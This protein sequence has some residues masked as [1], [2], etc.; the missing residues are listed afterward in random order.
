M[1]LKIANLY[2]LWYEETAGFH[3]RESLPYQSY[4]IGATEKSQDYSCS[5]KPFDIN[6]SHPLQCLCSGMLLGF[7]LAASGSFSH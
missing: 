7:L 5:R 2:M 4:L 1:L 3:V 6:L